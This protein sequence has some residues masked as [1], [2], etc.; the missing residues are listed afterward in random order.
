VHIFPF[1]K[2]LQVTVNGITRT[3]YEKGEILADAVVTVI[4]PTHTTPTG[5]RCAQADVRS[6]ET[7]RQIRVIGLENMADVVSHL[8]V[9]HTVNLFGQSGQYRGKNGQLRAKFNVESLADFDITVG[10]APDKEETYNEPQRQDVAEASY[11][12]DPIL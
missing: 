5:M 2:P 3:V 12:D 11:Q 7:G 10:P 4:W 9:G 8:P 6:L 1:S